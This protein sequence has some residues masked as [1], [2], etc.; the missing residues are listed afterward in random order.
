ML[1]TSRPGGISATS[2]AKGMLAVETQVHVCSQ[3]RREVAA[4]L[5]CYIPTMLLED[6]H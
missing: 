6:N 5:L 4:H 1:K 3:L 2:Q